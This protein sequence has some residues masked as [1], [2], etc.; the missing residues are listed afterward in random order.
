MNAKRSAVL[1]AACLGLGVLPMRAPHAR[2][3]LD[4]LAA[5]LNL[6]DPLRAQP[7]ALDAGR[8]LPGDAG[9]TLC[10]PAYDA[11]APL[12]L[13]AAVDLALCH[14]A[15]VHGAWAGIKMQAAGLGEAKAA[16]LPTLSAGLSR[17]NDRTAYPGSEARSTT[18]KSNTKSANFSS[19]LFDFG[20]RAANQR[21]AAALLDA[22][23]ANH[24]AVLQKTLAA[25]VGAYFDT[26]TALATF[27]ARQ[28]SQALAQETVLATQRRAQ[29]G[30]GS[31]SDTL[32]ATSALA[33][34]TLG[35]S[36][37]D[38]EYKKAR[39]MLVYTLGLPANT[40][41]TLSEDVNDTVASLREDLNEWLVQTRARHPAIL[42][43]Q[44]QLAAARERVEASRSEGRP[45]I[46]LT[47]NFYQNGRPNQG[48]TPASTRETLIG[49]AINIPLFDG[50]ARTYKVRGAQAQVEQKEA[51]VDEAK[52]QT[53]MELVKTHAEAGMALANLAASQA[54]LDAAQGALSSVQRKFDL[55]AADILEML[56]TQSALLDAQQERIRCLAEWRSAR[57]R[58]LASAG[59]L[60]KADLARREAQ[61]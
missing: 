26:Q 16:Y 53:L 59:T 12:T 46:D 58:L 40:P 21:S 50:F 47:A 30:L 35:T 22:A 34:A 44:A 57:L 48:L 14:N 38:G 24:D 54:W 56:N 60:G 29:R 45:S 32:Q 2:D 55:G 10:P 8:I 5:P 36:R 20:G 37:A 41:V 25:A 49:V 51:E 13:P 7:P 15:Q 3:I 33:K 11:T 6:G 39:A 18:L 61:Q 27:Q 43:A 52:Q 17:V 28:K 9:A 19:R 23:L 42:A 4:R 31:H 1:I